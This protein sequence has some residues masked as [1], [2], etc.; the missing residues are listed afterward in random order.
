MIFTRKMWVPYIVNFILSSEVAETEDIAKTTPKNTNRVS[1]QNKDIE[2]EN[3]SGKVAMI[4]GESLLAT[5][6]RA[7]VD[8]IVADFRKQADTDVP[9]MRKQFGADSP[10]A[11][12][13]IDIDAKYIESKKTESII[14]SVYSY[15]GGAHGSS[16]YKSFTTSIPDGKNPARLLSL[17]DVVK[18]DKEIAFTEFVKRELN[19]WRPENSS[20]SP[21]FP[22]EVQGLKFDSFTNWSFDSDNKN[23]IIYFSQYEIGPGVLGAV[24]FPLSI[25]KVSEFLNSNF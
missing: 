6:A 12:Y 25:E 8:E 16:F 15:T 20:S 11:Q 17:S 9:D 5:R 21:V 3:F 23:L 4:S 24:A 14:V 7:F 1:I 2:E 13:E 10:T 18:K 22:E 19:S